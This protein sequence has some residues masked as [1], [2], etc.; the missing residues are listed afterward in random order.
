VYRPDVR[1]SR[2][3]IGSHSIDLTPELVSLGGALL[4]DS[5]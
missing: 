5:T 1:D 4:I 3:A 2:D